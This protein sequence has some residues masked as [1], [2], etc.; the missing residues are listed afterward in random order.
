MVSRA[1]SPAAFASQPAGLAP[2]EGL[3]Q[4]PAPRLG[5]DALLGVE[6]DLASDGRPVLAD[7]VDGT[8]A[9]E[10]RQGALVVRGAKKGRLAR[11]WK[12]KNIE[13]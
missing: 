3:A 7:A 1:Q 4:H 8:P 13:A 5:A 9:G 12:K 6:D 10:H 2:S 11:I